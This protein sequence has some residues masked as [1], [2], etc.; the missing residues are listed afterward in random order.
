[1]GEMSGCNAQLQA[2]YAAS[3]LEWEQVGEPAVWES[4][5]ADCL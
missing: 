2:E 5:A 4:V 3:W 1:M